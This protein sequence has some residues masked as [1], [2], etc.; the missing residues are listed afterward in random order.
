MK[1]AD[2]LILAPMAGVTD[3]VFRQIA[4]EHGCNYSV[5]EMVSAKGMFYKSRGS[6]ELTEIN[7]EK[8]GQV[9]VQ[10]FGS[11]PEIMGW[12]AE[13]L[14][15]SPAC[16]ID[17]NMGCPVPKVFKNGEGSN[18]LTNPELAARIV[19]AVKEKT[20]KP[21]TAKMRIGIAKREDGSDSDYDY[22]SFAKALENAGLDRLYVHAR[23]RED[24]YSGKAYWPAIKKIK[25]GVKIPVG[26]NGD[27]ENYEDAQRMTDETGCDMVLVGRG[28]MGNPW[29]FE[30]PIETAL[31]HFE[32][33]LE[34]YGEYKAVREARKQVS[35]YTKGI[36]GSGLL[37][38]K[39]NSAETKEELRSI[40][41]EI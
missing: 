12:A 38:S 1:R 34:K 31:Y 24:Y 41:K 17:I 33:A 26:G 4:H 35:W 36:K 21:V 23:T 6:F 8:E 28:A 13:R 2:S 27:V 5:T 16:A 30:K 10:I 32:L 22:V 40:L 18:L 37:R 9:A 39:L 7:P 15:D 19:E 3:S 29:I 11:E 14:N 20:N 25:D